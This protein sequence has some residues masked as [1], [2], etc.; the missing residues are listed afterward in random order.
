MRACVVAAGLAALGLAACDGGTNNSSASIAPTGQTTTP[1]QPTSPGQPT[2]TTAPNGAVTESTTNLTTNPQAAVAAC[3]TPEQQRMSTDSMTLEQR[4]QAVG[5]IFAQTANQIR[6]QLPVKIDAVTSMVDIQAQGHVLR[7]S[8][9][10][11]VDAS[12]LPPTASAQLDQQTRSGTCGNPQTRAALDLGGAY[13]FTWSD[14]AG[15]PIHSVQI[16]SCT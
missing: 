12:S 11:E 13:A 14:R 15:Q 5:C 2:V 6:T 9:R 3:L 8:Y 1:G 10:V 7:Y 4:R 16:D